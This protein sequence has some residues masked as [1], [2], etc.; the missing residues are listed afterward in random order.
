[1]QRLRDVEAKY[2]TAKA[3]LA[4]VEQDAAKMGEKVI[5]YKQQKAIIEKNAQAQLDKAKLV[6]LKTKEQAK[7]LECRLAVIEPELESTRNMLQEKISAM[8]SAIETL[9]KVEEKSKTYQVTI[10]DLRKE[11]SALKAEHID[12]TNIKA[13]NAELIKMNSD[14]MALLEGK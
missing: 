6:V 1:M 7:K 4:E 13:E 10:Y 8:N 14:L 11:N 3:K 9:N 12:I 2:N 5:S